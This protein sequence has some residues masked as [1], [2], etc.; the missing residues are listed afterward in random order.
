MSECRVSGCSVC[1]RAGRE[2]RLNGALGVCIERKLGE[3]CILGL[4]LD[5]NPLVP[6]QLGTNNMTGTHIHTQNISHTEW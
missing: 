3:V 5:C 6:S 4:G 1:V 2:R